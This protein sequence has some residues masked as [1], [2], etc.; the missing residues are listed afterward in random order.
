MFIYQTVQNAFQKLVEQSARINQED[1]FITIL[2]AY[3]RSNGTEKNKRN[4]N[5]F[6]MARI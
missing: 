1:A 4:L 2:Q 6:Q 5:H 3:F